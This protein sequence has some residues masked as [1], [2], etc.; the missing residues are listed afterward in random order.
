MKIKLI[1]TLFTVMFFT[2]AQAGD[3]DKFNAN[4][5]AKST[6]VIE[7]STTAVMNGRTLPA[8]KGSL[9]GIEVAPSG[10]FK[11]RIKNCASFKGE[12]F[13][14]MTCTVDDYLDTLSNVIDN[15][16]VA[17]LSTA[18]Y[19]KGTLYN[20]LGYYSGCPNAYPSDDYKVIITNGKKVKFWNSLHCNIR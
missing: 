11:V 20:K 1:L 17:V 5:I 8:I 4:K 18:F 2:A 12:R 7:I 15:A 3:F 14:L 10:D 19:A 6:D 16:D 13:S 9:T